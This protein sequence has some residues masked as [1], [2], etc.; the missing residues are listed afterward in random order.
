V[1]TSAQAAVSVVVALFVAVFGV[2]VAE[3]HQGIDIWWASQ[4]FHK[5]GRFE[6][7][8]ESFEKI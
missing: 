5:A 4:A 1:L 6:D 3:R 7:R 8:R 2:P